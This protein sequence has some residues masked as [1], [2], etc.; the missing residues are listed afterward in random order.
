MSPGALEP[1]RAS[2]VGGVVLMLSPTSATCSGW[3]GSCGEVIAN[4]CENTPR[5][6]GWNPIENVAVSL[7]ASVVGKFG[8][9]IENG[10]LIVGGSSSSVVLLQFCRITR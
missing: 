10:A 7:G 5:L 1:G 2:V 6:V 8:L 3:L 4:V 9:S